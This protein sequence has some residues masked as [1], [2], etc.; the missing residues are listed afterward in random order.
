MP[1][2]PETIG[3]YEP[4]YRA[5]QVLQEPAFRPLPIENARPDWR[6]LSII[7]KM[8]R[9]GMHRRRGLTGLFSPRFQ[10]K[11]KVTGAVFIDHVKRNPGADV[12]IVN[13]SAHLPYIS[14][15]VWM[16]ADWYHPGLVDRAQALLDACGIGWSL[17]DTARQGPDVVC[18]SNFWIATEKVWDDYVGGVLVPIS[19]FMERHPESAVAQAVLAPTFHREPAPFLPFIVE[20]LFSTYLSHARPAVV[21]LLLD[22]LKTSVDRFRNGNRCIHA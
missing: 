20:R 22:P 1:N 18:Y 7:V 11:T 21:P 8:F 9:D 19:E 4:I 13:A 2:S 10:F 3:I 16:E 6:E 5:G 12:Y 14:Y 17:R 15:N